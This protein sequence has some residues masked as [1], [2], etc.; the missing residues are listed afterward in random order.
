[1]VSISLTVKL[2]PVHCKEKTLNMLVN[3]ICK[4]VVSLP[5]SKYCLINAPKF[6]QLNDHPSTLG[7]LKTESG[8]DEPTEFPYQSTNI[9]YLVK[10]LQKVATAESSERGTFSFI[11]FFPSL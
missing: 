5:I 3:E 7:K 8:H 6:N 11:P 10:N 4:D 1:M 2:E 9:I